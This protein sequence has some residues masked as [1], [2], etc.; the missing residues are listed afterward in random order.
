MQGLLDQAD[1]TDNLNTVLKSQKRYGIRQRKRVGKEEWKKEEDSVQET[2]GGEKAKYKIMEGP[3]QR[4]DRQ[5]NKRGQG[6][7]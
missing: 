6:P 4:R 3:N 1:W 2:K 7:R 5:E